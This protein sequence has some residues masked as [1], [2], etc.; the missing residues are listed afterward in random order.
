MEIVKTEN[1]VLSLINFAQFVPEKLLRYSRYDLATCCKQRSHTFEKLLEISASKK[2]HHQ[3]AQKMAEQTSTTNQISGIRQG[4]GKNEISN[5][6]QA[7]GKNEIRGTRQ[8]GGKNEIS[9]IQQ[10]GGKNKISGIQQAGG[11][12]EISGIQQDG[13]KNQITDIQQT[14][15]N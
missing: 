14:G 6:Q 12:N 10:A 8:A 1:E 7:G 4:G 5:I 11:K 2:V 3:E 9:G 13:G 15:G